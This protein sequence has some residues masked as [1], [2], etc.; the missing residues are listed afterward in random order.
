MVDQTGV[1]EEPGQGDHA[2]AEA[3]DRGLFR[4]MR[5]RPAKEKRSETEWVDTLRARPEPAAEEETESPFMAGE[6]PAPPEPEPAPEPEP[7]PEPQR[8]EE[9]RIERRWRRRHQDEMDEI[10]AYI[11]RVIGTDRDPMV[12]HRKLADIGA[13]R[14]P[15]KSR[16]IGSIEVEGLEE[17]LMIAFTFPQE[18]LRSARVVYETEGGYVIEVTRA[19]GGDDDRLERQHYTV[20]RVGS[21]AHALDTLR[22][23]EIEQEVRKSE[24]RHSTTQEPAQAYM[25][26]DVPVESERDA[27]HEAPQAEVAEVREEAEPPEQGEDT[28]TGI[29]GFASRLRRGRTDT[30]TPMEP[31]E[32]DEAEAPEPIQESQ[33][34]PEQEEEN[35]GEGGRRGIGS[36]FKRAQPEDQGEAQTD[37]VAPATELGAVEEPPE[38]APEEPSAA[39]TNKGGLGGLFKPRGKDKQEQPQG[40]EEAPEG[41]T[42]TEQVPDEPDSPAESEPEAPKKKG[43]FMGLRKR[44]GDKA[45][46]EESDE[47]P[48]EGEQ[49]DQGDQGPG[50]QEDETR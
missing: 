49:G 32:Q 17:E 15:P 31:A 25:P 6:A 7:E 29:M 9:Y 40:A 50:S 33:E 5:R 3:E 23:R 21:V 19:V 13:R 28:K 30:E 10:H 39:K 42:P 12:R 46:G 26:H 44:K 41:T 47:A 48:A 38:T 35:P 34:A 22:G 20:S 27:P 2:D 37:D 43:G 16:S 45:T 4:F 36:F 14:H 24:T 11:D 18:E 1:T 8:H